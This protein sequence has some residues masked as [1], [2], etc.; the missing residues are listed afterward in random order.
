VD[1]MELLLSRRSFSKLSDPAPE[2]D[3][4]ERILRAALRAPDHG[5]LRPFRILLVRG[6]ARERL[7]AL[8]AEVARDRR[9]G[10]GEDELERERR[11]PLR[12]PL[13]AIVVARI[14]PS[15]KIPDVEQRLAA[16]CVAHGLVIAA[17]AEGF[18]AIWRTGDLAYDR[19][20]H[21]RLGLGGAD[22]ILG[23]VYLGTPSLVPPDAARPAVADHV[24]DWTG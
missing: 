9:P 12:A 1:A 3:A 4:L 13:I 23:F 5:M 22:Q 17:Q 8:M 7:G 10:I 24:E 15:A 6:E 20:V 18:G 11:K 2:G 21:A 14:R 19:S 16:G